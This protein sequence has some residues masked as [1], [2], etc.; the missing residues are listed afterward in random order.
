[1]NNNQAN[2][3]NW[4]RETGVQLVP[5]AQSVPAMRDPYGALAGYPGSVADA[6][7]QSGLNLLEY[8]RILNKRKWLILSIAAAFVVL[9]AVR[10]LM[11]TPLYTATVRLQIDRNV[12]KI[13]EGDNVTPVEDSNSQ[14]MR[15]QYELLQSRMMAERVASALKLTN[16]PDF[17]K[18][19][20]FSIVDAV[21]GLLQPAPN[22]DVN[23]TVL[24]RTAAGLVQ[25]NLG[26][27]PVTGSRLVDVSYSDPVPDRAQ[28]IANAYA[29]AFLAS[30][31]NK[32]FQANASAKTF[33][34]DKIQQLKLRLEEFGKEGARVCA[35]QADHRYQR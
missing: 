21:M 17:F 15:T 33:L 16:D 7:E 14:F 26:V 24:E 25:A 10:T 32:R 19:R 28:R 20:E 23:E 3:P 11:Q 31:V 4:N 13:V 30:N 18:T 27:Q 35:G 22:P 9:A 5:A 29:D 6:P 1:M 12:A 8:W 2:E 34:E